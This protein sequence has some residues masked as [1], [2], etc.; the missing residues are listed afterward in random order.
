MA[1]DLIKAART[2]MRNQLAQA[3]ASTELEK[4]GLAL[5]QKM[6]EQTFKKDATISEDMGKEVLGYISKA[7]SVKKRGANPK[8]D[9]TPALSGPSAGKGNTRTAAEKAAL[10]VLTGKTSTSATVVKKVL[11]PGN[12]EGIRQ[13]NK[14]GFQ[15]TEEEINEKFDDAAKQLEIDAND[16]AVK[17]KFRQLGIPEETF[18]SLTGNLQS[19]IK[20]LSSKNIGKEVVTAQKKM[21]ENQMTQ[22]SNPFGSFKSKIDVP[23]LN[24]K[25]GDALAPG[26]NLISKMKAKT[27]LTEENLSVKNPFGSMGVDF[28]NIQGT[29][30]SLANGGP[31]F[32][33]LNLNLPS[34]SGASNIAAT[35]L[36]ADK[37]PDI[38]NKGGFT[39]L[40]ETVSKTEI[41][42]DNIEPSTPVE[43]IGVPMNRPVTTLVYTT[44]HTSEEIELELGATKR[45]I[46]I[47]IARWTA[48]TS[49]RRHE[50]AKIYNEKGM[51][52]H[53]RPSN[54]HYMILRDGTVQRILNT[55]VAPSLSAAVTASSTGATLKYRLALDNIYQSSLIVMFDAGYTCTEAEK[56]DKFLSSQS[57]TSE[58]MDSY[59][60]IVEAAVKTHPGAG[61]ISMDLLQET[62]VKSLGA[63]TSTS[64][65]RLG[66]GFNADKYRE[67][68][69]VGADTNKYVEEN[70]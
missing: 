12:I 40:Q 2:A 49:D 29:I 10:D 18:T 41:I 16:P 17:E 7:A 67:N 6:M 24:V 21:S 70:K 28:G 53:G 42:P 33:D 22:L 62:I 30:A 20:E 51:E 4:E 60:M 26:S 44:A 9:P 48:S 63:T 5:A 39:N 43:E 37:I 36:T 19:G 35:G 25:A 13:A 56:N 68:L 47:F 38:V 61:H 52:K 27:G 45:N 66:A 15:L 59:R 64:V 69:M 3:K 46:G 31:A 23:S 57:I 65:L 1:E 34:V 11:T 54:A 8:P 50:S 58:Q 14:D 55:E 32:K